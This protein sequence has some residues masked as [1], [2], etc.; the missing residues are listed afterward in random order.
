MVSAVLRRS[1]DR[2]QAFM[3]AG[4][5]SRA[6]D[7]GEFRIAG[8]PDGEYLVMAAPAPQTPFGQAP[9][10]AGGTVL[11]PTQDG[12]FQIDGVIS[13]TYRAMAG[14][15]TSWSG[16]GVSGGVVSGATGGTVGGGSDRPLAVTVS[17]SDVTG[18]TIV[19]A[20]RT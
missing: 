4:G 8:L 6:N 11:A 2:G 14:I 7:I 15:S 19:V 9:T 20:P 1:A 18:L 3:T 10:A 13:V 12:T 16:G 17:D 5:P